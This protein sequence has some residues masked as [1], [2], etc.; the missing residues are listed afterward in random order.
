MS[1]ITTGNHP[2]ALWPGVAAWF[3]RQYD[4]YEAQY[5]KLFDT[6]TSEKNY[7]EDVQ[8]TGFGLASIKTEGA[9]ITYDTETQGFTKRYTHVVYGSGYIVTREEMED[10]QYETLFPSVALRLSR[11]PLA[12][13]RK[14]SAPTSITGRSILRIPAATASAF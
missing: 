10:S 6:E 4:E 11:S 14:T 3:G 9:S 5:T 1:V 7:E 12:R 13:P 8:V 2:K